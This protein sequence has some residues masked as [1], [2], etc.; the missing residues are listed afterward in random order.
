MAEGQFV[1]P[2]EQ[3]SS[4]RK[5]YLFTSSNSRKLNS[6]TKNCSSTALQSKLLLTRLIR[7]I[8]YIHKSLQQVLF[9]TCFSWEG[10]IAYGLR[11]RAN[12]L[13]NGVTLDARRVVLSTGKTACIMLGFSKAVISVHC[14]MKKKTHHNVCY[15]G[16]S[17]GKIYIGDDAWLSLQTVHTRQYDS[18]HHTTVIENNN[19]FLKM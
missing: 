9:H 6:M 3:N 2:T 13:W 19:Q 11:V 17:P 14:T 1:T 15:V 8:W 16:G 4:E 5:E 18:Q 10:I 7:Y 12:R